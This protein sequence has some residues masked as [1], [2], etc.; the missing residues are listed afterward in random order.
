MKEIVRA[1]LKHLDE[2]GRLFNLYRIFYEEEDDI[3]KA[4]N[5]ITARFKNEDSIIFA[6]RSQD[7]T[8]NGFVQ[9]Y[10]SYCSVSTIPILI[11]YDLFVDES[12]RAKGKGRLLMNAARDYAKENGYKRLEL[13][14]AKDN[15]I[16]QSLY[17]SL[18]YALDK[19]FLQY[20]LEID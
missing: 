17:E 1:E 15:Y 5:Y 8:L 19:E 14:T 2:L 16:G 13:S 9:L 6:S 12:E 18:G 10:P 11:L 3:E 7:S 20:S 4:T